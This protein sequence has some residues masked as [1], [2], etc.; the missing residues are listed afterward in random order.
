MT[1]TVARARRVSLFGVPGIAVAGALV[2][3][4]AVVL[5]LPNKLAV[6]LLMAAA[7]A[8]VVATRVDLAVAI[9][10]FVIFTEAANVAVKGAGFTLLAEL[11][12][13]L[14]L[15]AHLGD[16]RWVGTRSGVGRVVLC[17]VPFV[18]WSLASFFWAELPVPVLSRFA[19]H[20]RYLGIALVLV[21]AIRTERT[22]RFAVWGIIAGGAFLGTV[23]VLQAV[24]RSGASDFFF[25]F[26]G[27][28]LQ[29]LGTGE[30]GERVV[31]PLGDANF[32]AQRM[33]VVL[34]FA[35]ERAVN[36]RHVGARLVAGL[37]VVVTLATIV[38][39]YSRGGALAGGVVLLVC[40]FHFLPARRALVVLGVLALATMLLAPRPYVDRVLA[41][42]GVT[43]VGTTEDSSVRGR[44][45]AVL[46]GI[47]MFE[48]HPFLGVGTL[49]YPL[50]Y[51]D[52]ATTI[53]LDPVV[54]R[55]PHNLYVEV[56]SENGIVGVVLFGAMLV[57]ALRSSS[58]GMRRLR[59]A[60]RGG[61][62]EAVWAVRT[63]L[64]GYLVAALFLHF[65]YPRVLFTLI[66]MCIAAPFLVEALP[67]RPRP[68][69]V[70]EPGRPPAPVPV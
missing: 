14:V 11:I 20:L 56:A 69:A 51:A 35:V 22:L 44:T 21:A 32:F 28:Q 16:R 26:G 66:A 60:D 1:S 29:G 34:P 52:Y 39:T 10:V 50:H 36:G 57:V 64:V 19:D 13:G 58:T 53:G 68:L 9:F 3:A 12:T 62:A 55:A 46:V 65:A 70:V 7:L 61:A 8:F 59:A 27:V 5:L 17:V 30:A 2:G 40:L 67:A 49:Q 41:L 18:L 24:L 6:I 37:T 38:L 25:G 31:G 42:R 33:V 63:A 43:S 47:T 23:A 15:L 4:A 48:D 45:S 54:G